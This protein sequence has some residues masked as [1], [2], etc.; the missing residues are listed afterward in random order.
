MLLAMADFYPVGDD[1]DV[2]RVQT[3]VRLRRTTHEDVDLIAEIWNELDAALKKKRP[4]KWKAS[5]TIEQIIE[6]GVQSIWK[7][8][9]GR[10]ADKKE[11]A[12]FVKR[13]IEAIRSRA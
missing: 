6:V 3:T 4:K 9:G 12:E 5:N 13:A 1:E 10:P 8:Y 2:E 7:Q 11:R